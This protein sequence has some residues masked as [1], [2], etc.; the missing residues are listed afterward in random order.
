MVT[1]EKLNIVLRVPDD[2]V[3]EYLRQGYK[4]VE[5]PAAKPAAPEPKPVKK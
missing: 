5:A 3:T 4:R 2:Q 1:I